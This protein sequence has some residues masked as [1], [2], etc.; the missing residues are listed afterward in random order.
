MAGLDGLIVPINVVVVVLFVAL[1]LL[2]VCLLSSFL[3]FF[4][5]VCDIYQSSDSHGMRSSVEV[6]FDSDTSSKDESRITLT[7]LGSS[8]SHWYWYWSRSYCPIQ[9]GKTILM[10]KKSY[11]R[12]SEIRRIVK[13]WM[14]VYGFTDSSQY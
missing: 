1:L 9:K 4:S 14:F 13:V 11:V 7:S 2:F 3:V 10:S 6:R 5:D 12:T 8:E